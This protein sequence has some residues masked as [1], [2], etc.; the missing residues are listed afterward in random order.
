MEPVLPLNEYQCGLIMVPKLYSNISELRRGRIHILSRDDYRI[1]TDIVALSFWKGI[2]VSKTN[3]WRGYKDE[4]VTIGDQI[5]KRRIQ[6]GLLQKDVARI[7]NVSEDC[8]TYW[9][10]NRSSPQKR[11]K[12]LILQFLNT[13][14]LN[15]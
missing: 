2:F 15:K 6:L 14:N 1:R 3:K 12:K 4:I 9:E 5:R 10:N 11:Y 8:I 7:I 13:D